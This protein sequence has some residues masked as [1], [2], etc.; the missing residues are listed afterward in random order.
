MADAGLPERER[1]GIAFDVVTD[2]PDEL[3]VD[4]GR[5]DRE[6]DAGRQPADRE[7]AASP[8]VAPSPV[9]GAT[10]TSGRPRTTITRRR[11]VLD[12]LHL[13]EADVPERARRSVR[14]RRRSS[15]T[16]RSGS[17]CAVAAAWISSRVT[18]ATAGR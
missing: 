1:H 3:H 6:R 2:A 12:D 5:G 4:A 15:T 13:A 8:P 10:T 18:A 7:A 11:L 17:R 9:P 16:A 14:R